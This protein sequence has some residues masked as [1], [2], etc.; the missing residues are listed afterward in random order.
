MSAVILSF[1]DRRA[2]RPHMQQEEQSAE[3]KVRAYCFKLGLNNFDRAAVARIVSHLQD[4]QAAHPEITERVIAAR[5]MAAAHRL[6]LSHQPD[7]NGPRAA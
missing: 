4:C 3:S 1:T 2:T 7:P 6:W 5:G